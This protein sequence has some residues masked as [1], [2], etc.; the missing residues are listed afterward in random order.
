MPKPTPKPKPNPNPKPKPKPNP[1]PNPKPNPN[2]A[3]AAA[4]REL[5]HALSEQQ[6]LP[7]DQQ[8]KAG[9]AVGAE[10]TDGRVLARQGG[11]TQSH[12]A[13]HRYSWG[14]APHE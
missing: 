2:Q 11:R 10:P 7:A 6:P 14:T 13:R 8:V 5:P 12:E 4:R 9:R 1:N 3:G